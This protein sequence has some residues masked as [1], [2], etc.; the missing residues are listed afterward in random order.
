MKIFNLNKKSA[1]SILSY[2][3][4]GRFFYL[5]FNVDVSYN[6]NVDKTSLYLKI[7]SILKYS[8]FMDFLLKI[9]YK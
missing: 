2:L 9:E 7:K 4:F 5:L 3:L 1:E 8:T 6:V